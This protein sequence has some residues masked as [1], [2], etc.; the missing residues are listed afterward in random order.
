MHRFWLPLTVCS[1]A[2]AIAWQSLRADAPAPSNAAKILTLHTRSRKPGPAPDE[3]KNATV[4]EKTVP[5]DPKKTALLIIDMWDDHWCHG[6]AQRTGE[7]AVPMNKLVHKARDLGILIV[8]APSSCC[9]F[10]KGTPARQRAL[11][12]ALVDPPSSSGKA[13]G[14]GSKWCSLDKQHEPAM[15]IVD[16]DGGCDCSPHCKSHDAWKSQ[17]KLIDIED[18]DVISDN[19]QQIYSLMQERGID[20][21]LVMGVHLNMCVLGRPFGIRS[22]TY[23]GKNVLLIRDMTDTM[24]N[25]EMPPK[26]DH[27]AGTDLMVQHVEAYWCPTITSVDFLG[28]TPFHFAADP[29]K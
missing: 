16:S 23:L 2:L 21:V 19:G 25:H 20:N 5:L 7:L 14:W 13:P 9:D 12:V 3:L 17:I 11:D 10:Y 28:G 27:F 24:Y 8:H 29:H 26:V 4:E 18:S 6:A 15:P 22:Q 1:L